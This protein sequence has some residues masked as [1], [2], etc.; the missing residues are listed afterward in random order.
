MVPN[1]IVCGIHYLNESGVPV[2]A[3]SLIGSLVSP[4]GKRT[5]KSVGAVSIC[6]PCLKD[7]G[8]GVVV[9]EDDGT[10]DMEIATVQFTHG[11]AGYQR[12][13]RCPSCRAA[14]TYSVR[15]HRARV[16]EREL[17]SAGALNGDMD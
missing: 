14:N 6:R 16:R 17:V 11:S 1:C 3:F 15:R 4:A 2:Y 5:S 12:G 7:I 8:R 10:G 9:P 13:C